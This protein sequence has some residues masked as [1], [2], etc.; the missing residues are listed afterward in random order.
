M[1]KILLPQNVLFERFPFEICQNVFKCNLHYSTIKVHI[2]SNKFYDL[3]VSVPFKKRNIIYGWDLRS[4]WSRLKVKVILS[5]RMNLHS[6][7]LLTVFVSYGY[8]WP[9]MILSFTLNLRRLC[10]TSLSY[11]KL[12]MF[13]ATQHSAKIALCYSF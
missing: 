2:P 13:C 12:G 1:I 10:A 11:L 5:V 6:F 7:E 9:K 4:L 8:G 3:E